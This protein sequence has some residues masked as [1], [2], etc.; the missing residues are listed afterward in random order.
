MKLSFSEAY[1]FFEGI[2]EGSKADRCRKA[3]AEFIAKNARL[4]QGI[5]Q[6]AMAARFKRMVESRPK[7][8]REYELSK[9]GAKVFLEQDL[10]GKPRASLDRTD[11][12]TKTQ[13]WRLASNIFTF[14]TCVLS[15]QTLIVW[16]KKNHHKR[17]YIH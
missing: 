2:D 13:V 10:K 14:C 1:A 16:S 17:D 9:W 8:A 11:L 15:L 7:S 12:C 4:A 6:E 5:N 3:A